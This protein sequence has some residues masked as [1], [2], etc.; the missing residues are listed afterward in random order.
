MALALRY[1]L[2][3]KTCS[4]IRTLKVVA[5][6]GAARGVAQQCLHCSLLMAVIGMG[7]THYSLSVSGC[8]YQLH[9]PPDPGHHRQQLPVLD[10][11]LQLPGACTHPLTYLGWH[12][13]QHLASSLSHFTSQLPRIMTYQVLS[14]HLGSARKTT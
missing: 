12:A 7:K 4:S 5:T 10:Q 9:Y 1:G 3:A 2:R 11:P 14:P 13:I 8:R 6:V